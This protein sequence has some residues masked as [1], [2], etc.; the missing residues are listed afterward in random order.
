[1]ASKNDNYWVSFSDIMTGLMVVFLLISVSYMHLMQ[2]KYEGVGNQID[3]IKEIRDEIKNDLD[4]VFADK[5]GEWNAEISDDLSVKFKNPILLFEVGSD[6]I[7]PHFQ[8]ILRE[9]VPKYLDVLLKEEYKDKIAEIR[10]EGHTDNTPVRGEPYDPYIDNMALSQARARRIVAMIRRSEK[11]KTLTNEER[12]NLEFLLTAN[13]MS[14][15]KAL[16]KDYN[17]IYKTGKSIDLDKSRRVEFKV[18]VSTEDILNDN[19]QVVLEKDNDRTSL[20]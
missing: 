9:F 15:S 4:S 3:D 18:V 19:S 17:L 16:D 13:G 11:Y 20:E 6:E 1:M 10:V 5:L 12:K 14:Y 7:T 8:S 2:K